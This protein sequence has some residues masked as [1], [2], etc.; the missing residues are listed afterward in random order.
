MGDRAETFVTEQF[1]DI[2][3]QHEL[4]TLAVDAHFG[5]YRKRSLLPQL[6]EE[7]ILP[8]RAQGYDQVWLL[9]IS[10][11][12]FGSLLYASEHADDI[13]GLILLAPYV[14]DDKIIRDVKA[15]GRIADWNP[16][17]KGF[18][19]HEVAVW[20]WLQQEMANPN[21]K[22]I[23]LGY[24]RSDRLAE[25]YTPLVEVMNSNRVYARDGNHKWTTWRPLWQEIAAALSL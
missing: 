8:A 21:G 7:V 15:S 14:G 13:D 2:G 12:G 17:G 18:P 24:G 22:P 23:V 3:E 6:R 11:G 5:Y 16:D 1:F 9:G 25:A 20:R 4:A 19:D 10:L